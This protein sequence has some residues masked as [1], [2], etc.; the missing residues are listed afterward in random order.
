MRDEDALRYRGWRYPF[1][2]STAQHTLLG[3]AALQTP[4]FSRHDSARRYLV[5][6]AAARQMSGGWRTVIAG[7][8]ALVEG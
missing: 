1:A 4:R 8:V 7:E 6:Q 2:L 3:G 5:Y